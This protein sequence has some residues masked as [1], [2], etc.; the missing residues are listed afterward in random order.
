MQE[1]FFGGPLAAI[2]TYGMTGS[3]GIGA[4][5]RISSA[6]RSPPSRWAPPT[7]VINGVTWVA[8]INGRKQMGNWGEKA[9]LTI[10]IKAVVTPINDLN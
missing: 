8:P 2:L 3:L 1:V 9:L 7:I 5:R 6:Q 10:V 4:W